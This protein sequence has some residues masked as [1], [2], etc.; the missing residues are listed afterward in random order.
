[1]NLRKP[2]FWDQKKPNIYAYI[3]FPITFLIQIINRIKAQQTKKKFKI[4]TICIGNFYAGGTGKTSLS[5]KLKE[6]LENKNIKTCFVKKFYKEQDD[7][8]K[9]LKKN[10]SLILSRNRIRAIEEAQSENFEVAILDDGLQD[11]SID[12]DVRIVCFNNINWKG[13]GM[14]IPSGPLR[15]NINNLKDY[16]HLF[17]NG[18]LENIDSLK[19]E[20]LTINPNINIYT[21]KYEATNINEFKKNYNYLVFSGIGNHQTFISMLKNY[22]LIVLKDIEFP[23]HYKYSN[24][25]LEFIIS[26][27]KRLNCKIITTE[28]DYLRFENV[29]LEEIKFI[30]SRLKIID[31]MKFINSIT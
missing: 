27:S 30:K 19:K 16:K 15:E 10:G 28:K 3:L 17:L 5:I 12:Y 7:E 2:K 23:D 18:N 20:I 14:T 8:Q 21:G 31:E 13:N 26:E 25:D 4:K 29:N 24:K 22:G 11:K 9:I 6:I 1:M